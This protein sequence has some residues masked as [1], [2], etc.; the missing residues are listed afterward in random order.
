MTEES[1]AQLQGICKRAGEVDGGYASWVGVA[2]AHAVHQRNAASLR[3]AF[4][5]GDAPSCGVSR[6]GCT[7]FEVRLG[8]VQSG[9][10]L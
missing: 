2:I 4:G 8:P 9:I 10:V 6:K 3:S 5:P 1:L 7:G